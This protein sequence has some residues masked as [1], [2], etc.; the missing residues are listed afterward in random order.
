[1]RDDTK[2]WLNYADDNLKSSKILL[3]S[4]LFNPCLHNI[5]QTVEKSLKAILIEKEIKLK[6]THDIYELKNLLLDEGIAVA[7]SDDDCD[8]INAI[9]MPSKYP[10]ISVLPEFDPDESMCSRGIDIAERVI[11]SVKRCLN[12]TALD[13]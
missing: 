1:M 4:F 10:I 6:R 13:I 11:N 8:F 12:D 9:Y 2:I 3:E 7:L 5:Q